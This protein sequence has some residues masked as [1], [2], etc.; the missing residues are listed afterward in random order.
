MTPVELL[1]KKRL[2]VLTICI[3]VGGWC[4]VTPSREQL[5]LASFSNIQGVSM[6]PGPWVVESILAVCSCPSDTY[7]YKEAVIDMSGTCCP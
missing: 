7:V 2:A 5:S 3:N 1:G 4:L 6:C